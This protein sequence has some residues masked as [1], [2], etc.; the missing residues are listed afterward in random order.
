MNRQ[1]RVRD[2]GIWNN[3]GP[4]SFKEAAI[5][6]AEYVKNMLHGRTHVIEV[7]DAA[8]PQI[9]HTLTVSRHETYHVKGLRKGD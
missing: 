7:R 9:V 4:V 3:R 6:E 8:E 2:N 5:A 1:S